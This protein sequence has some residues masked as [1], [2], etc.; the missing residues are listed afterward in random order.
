MSCDK[1]A[2]NLVNDLY[3]LNDK[4][5]SEMGIDKLP[6]KRSLLN[7]KVQKTLTCLK[8][9]ED[10]CSKTNYLLQCG[11]T[12][13]VL[14]EY[15]ADCEE[16]LSKVVK[17]DPSLVD[18]WN[19]LGETFWKKADII[20]AKN[21][22]EGAL[23]RKKNVVSLR[24]LSMVYR[25]VKT[26]KAGDSE[27]SILESVTCAKDAVEL[28]VNDGVSWYVLGNAYLSLFF[29]TSQNS[30]VL[31]LAL[32]CYMKAESVENDCKN[33]P[34]LHFNRAQAY[35][36][37]EDFSLALEGWRMASKLDPD[38]S[39]PS[40]KIKQ[41]VNYLD[42]ITCLIEEKG[43]LKN[44]KIQL[45][46]KSFSSKDLGPYA[47]GA[48]YEGKVINLNHVRIK[49]LKEGKNIGSII[50]MKVLSNMAH[51]TLVPFTFIAMDED[52]LVFAVSVYNLNKTGGVI[53]G[54]TVAIPN[55]LLASQSVEDI[56]EEKTEK[57]W[58]FKSIRVDNPIE[59]VINKRKLTASHCCYTKASM[60]A[61]D[62]VDQILS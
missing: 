25:Q 32:N 61:T 37:K 10:N 59:L 27:K 26:E 31:T 58:Q 35:R 50:T 14:P 41:L 5:V 42:N 55:P 11:R 13:N 43:K 6:Q 21:C 40:E 52:S 62:S 12:L 30:K 18:G 51:L 39:E 45:L 17:R 34:D 38:W 48:L 2:I 20:A 29:M 1:E 36:Y 24:S 56:K 46:L 57:K 33:N 53:I 44:R 8:E 22:F 16:Y 7:D 4:F 15:S 3:D 19:M 60:T 23:K 28:D 54:D 47:D 49:D 9:M